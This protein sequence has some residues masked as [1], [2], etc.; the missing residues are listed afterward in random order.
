MKNDL[1]YRANTRKYNGLSPTRSQIR[2]KDT[3]INSEKKTHK[4]S[5]NVDRTKVFS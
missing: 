2:T 1:H 5:G 3:K 4:K